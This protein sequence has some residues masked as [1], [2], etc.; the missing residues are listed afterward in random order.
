MGL[1]VID[2]W[3]VR[4]EADLVT[5]AFDHEGHIG[6]FTINRRTGEATPPVPEHRSGGHAARHAIIKAWRAGA[7]PTRAQWAG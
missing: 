7:L 4:E 2:I 5:Y 1:G 6:H 3:Q